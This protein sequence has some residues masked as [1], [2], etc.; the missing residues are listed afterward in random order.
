MTKI[1]ALRRADQMPI[2]ET[3]FVDGAEFLLNEHGQEYPVTFVSF[4]GMMMHWYQFGC[5]INFLYCYSDKRQKKP[6]TSISTISI[7]TC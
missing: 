6:S 1:K 2:Y 7:A 3:D 5:S 4:S